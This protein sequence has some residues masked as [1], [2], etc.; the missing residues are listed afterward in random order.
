MRGTGG[1]RFI[2]A[3]ATR[4]DLMGSINDQLGD[5]QE[6][7]NDTGRVLDL[8]EVSIYTKRIPSGLISVSVEA[9]LATGS[10]THRVHNHPPYRPACTE[11]QVNGQ[12]RGACL[13]DDGSDR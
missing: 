1:N 5:L 3:D 2:P 4:A 10:P 13:N 8:A 9:D 6:W 11:R 12:L 7:A